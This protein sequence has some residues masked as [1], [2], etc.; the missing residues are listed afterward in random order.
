VF[1][2]I[3]PVKVELFKV[4]FLGGAKLFTVGCG[5]CFR[6]LSLPPMNNFGGTIRF[7]GTIYFGGFRPPVLLEAQ[8]FGKAESPKNR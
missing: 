2:L 7:L 3:L 1:T 5:E 6:G 4:M 8:G